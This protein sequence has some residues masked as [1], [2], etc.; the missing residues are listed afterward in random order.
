MQGVPGLLGNSDSLAGVCFSQ[1]VIPKCNHVTT[2]T[3]LL[4]NGFN[5]LLGSF[6]LKETL[7]YLVYLASIGLKGWSR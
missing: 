1:V 7:E 2:A 3:L 4:G 6:Q 5:P